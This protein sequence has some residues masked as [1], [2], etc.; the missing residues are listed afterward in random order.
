[1]SEAH[2]A[3]GPHVSSRTY[4][5]I[6]IV[7]AVLTAMELM[8]FYV[9]ALSP[10]LIPILMVLMSAKFTLVMGWFMHL[11][12]DSPILTAIISWGLLLATLIILGLMALFGKF[13]V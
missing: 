12:F 10:L 8:V 7:L 11:R 13:D 2:E 3:S 1:M 4:V 5:M 6:A 9:E